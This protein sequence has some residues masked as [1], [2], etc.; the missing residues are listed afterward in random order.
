M[1]PRP[2]L[3]ACG[4]L[5][6]A[7]LAS[8]A[9]VTSNQADC[10]AGTGRIFSVDANTVLRCLQ[11]G[12][13][14]INGSNAADAGL[15]ASGWSFVDSSSGSGGAHDG[16]L[17][18]SLLSGLSGQ[19]QINPSAWTT[20]DRIAIGFK[21][22]VAQADPDWAIFELAD[23]TTSGL[24]SISGSS[25]ALSHAILYGFGTPPQVPQPPSQFQ[26]IP[27]PPIGAL[28]WV[29][30]MFAAAYLGRARRIAA[31]ARD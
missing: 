3:R 4:A 25:Q 11:A 10:H 22:G 19:F 23:H 2:V 30:P 14:N 27:E 24:W 21:S 18:G 7:P 28:V 15:I 26:A 31:R 17:T 13:G 1:T 9:V 5:L 29:L 12:A 16:W 8:A 6:L 20:Y